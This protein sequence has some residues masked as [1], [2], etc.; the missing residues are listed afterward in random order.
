[1]KTEKSIGFSNK[2][3]CL[4]YNAFISPCLVSFVLAV[5]GVLWALSFLLISRWYELNSVSKH[6]IV[7]LRFIKRVYYWLQEPCF[8][9]GKD[10][11]GD[12]FQKTL[13]IY[14]WDSQKSYQTP[15][16]LHSFLT[17]SITWRSPVCCEWTVW[18]ITFTYD[19]PNR[20][21]VVGTVWLWLEMWVERL[22]CRRRLK[23][24]KVFQLPS[25][26]LQPDPTLPD[27]TVQTLAWEDWLTS[28]HGLIW[29][30]KILS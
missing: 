11:K 12:I 3:L 29:R 10:G 13:H 27:G 15:H 14:P 17:D 26:A 21:F 16:V 23:I 28:G 2:I 25:R 4:N 1:M 9:N 24:L 8:Y 22:N 6:D 7:L 18:V 19:S 5:Y 20:W 30:L